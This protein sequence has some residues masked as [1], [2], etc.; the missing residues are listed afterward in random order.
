MGDLVTSII[1]LLA[2]LLAAGAV[3]LTGV[4][5][6]AGPAGWAAGLAGAAVLLLVASF[7]MVRRA[8]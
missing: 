7:V 6:L 3:V 5:V 1:E 2:L 8:R 4:A